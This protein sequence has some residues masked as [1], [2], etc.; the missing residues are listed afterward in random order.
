MITKEIING[1]DFFAVDD[2]PPHQK[3]KKCMFE[4]F[5]CQ[6]APCIPTRRDDNRDVYFQP[7]HDLRNLAAYHVQKHSDMQ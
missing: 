6:D 2:E 4:K 1:E 7:V 3:C 5:Y